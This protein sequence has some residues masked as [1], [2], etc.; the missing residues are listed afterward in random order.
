MLTTTITT[1]DVVPA[2]AAVVHRDFLGLKGTT[3][4]LVMEVVALE[5]MVYWRREQRWKKTWYCGI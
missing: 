2:A 5:H 1:T 4:V 3:L